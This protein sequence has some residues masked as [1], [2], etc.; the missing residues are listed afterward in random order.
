LG[1][2]EMSGGQEAGGEAEIRGIEI[3]GSQSCGHEAR[4][5]GLGNAPTRQFGLVGAPV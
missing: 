4:L 2:G 1:V 5:R 3:P